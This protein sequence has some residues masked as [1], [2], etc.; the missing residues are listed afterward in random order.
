LG[1]SG[2]RGG[3]DS[4]NVSA[5]FSLKIANSDGQQLLQPDMIGAKLY[6]WFTSIVL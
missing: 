2:G 5:V 3:G 1:A 4:C 6:F